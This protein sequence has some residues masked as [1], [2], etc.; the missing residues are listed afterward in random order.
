MSWQAPSQARLLRRGLGSYL[1]L[2]GCCA[3]PAL[4]ATAS[5]M[6]GEESREILGRTLAGQLTSFWFLAS[7]CPLAYRF[8]VWVSGTTGFVLRRGSHL[9]ALLAFLLLAST[10]VGVMRVVLQPDALPLA[11]SVAMELRAPGGRWLIQSLQLRH[12]D[13]ADEHRPAGSGETASA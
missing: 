2:Y 10:M 7:L 8:S 11:D 4:L 1:L 5:V 3:V 9:L 6:T 13:G 12:H